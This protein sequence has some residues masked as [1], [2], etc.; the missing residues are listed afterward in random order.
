MEF[1]QYLVKDRVATITLNRA[2]KRNAFNA[3]LVSEL[4]IAFTQAEQNVGV[5]VIILNAV[6]KVFSAGADLGALK[7][8]QTNT[9][10]ENLADSQHLMQLFRQIYQMPKPVIA[11]VQGHAIAGGCGL[12]TV[13]DFC[14]AV[15]EAKFGYTEVKIGFVPALVMVFLVRKLGETQTK[16]L[17]LTGKLIQASEA[18]RIGLITDTIAADQIEQT[19]YNLAQQLCNTTSAQSLALTKTMLAR[20]QEMPINDALL[21]AAE[22]NAQSRGRSDCQKGIAAFLNKEKISW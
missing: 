10:D 4:K 12:A 18:A 19:V 8:L 17:L 21:Y 3:Q 2:E 16:N 14:F 5:K 20:V 22:A 6:G 11:Q 9:F 1:V 15:P 13:C 7:L